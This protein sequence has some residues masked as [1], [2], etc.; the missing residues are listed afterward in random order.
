MSIGRRRADSVG[1]APSSRPYERSSVPCMEPGLVRS[2]ADDFHQRLVG[3]W[4][5][6]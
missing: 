1:A 4:T 6:S 3:A 2:M 5:R